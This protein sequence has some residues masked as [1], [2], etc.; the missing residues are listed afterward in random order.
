MMQTADFWNL[1]HWTERRRLDGSAGRG[2]R[3]D[4][5]NLHRYPHVPECAT[6]LRLTDSRLET[7]FMNGVAPTLAAGILT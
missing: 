1:D 4:L 6:S 7:A 5:G 3:F 2:L